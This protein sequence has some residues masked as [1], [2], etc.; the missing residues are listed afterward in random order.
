M[1]NSTLKQDSELLLETL[2]NL[3]QGRQSNC[4][5]FKTF[6]CKDG[7]V[8]YNVS[9]DFQHP[10]KD[11]VKS[12]NNDFFLVSKLP[13]ANNSVH[14]DSTVSECFDQEADLTLPILTRQ[15][16]FVG[17]P[18]S[19]TQYHLFQRNDLHGWEAETVEKHL[20]LSSVKKLDIKAAR[21]FLSLYIQCL[22]L[23][24]GLPEVWLLCNSTNPQEVTH[25]GMVPHTEEDPKLST[26]SL[27]QVNTVV[28]RNQNISAPEKDGFTL[29]EQKKMHVAFNKARHADTH[30]FARYNIFGALGSFEKDDSHPESSITMEF[31]WDGVREILQPP[32]PS[33]N[34]VLNIC[35][36]PEDVKNI[37]PAITSEL[38]AL[39][40]HFAVIHGNLCESAEEED[41]ETFDKQELEANVRAFL[42]DLK[43]NS[44]G[45]SEPE[46]ISQS[47]SSNV[48]A[49]F[50][51][52]E[53]L[54]R[55]DLDN[56]E[57]L[58]LFFKDFTSAEKIVFCLQII[59]SS[60]FQGEYQPV[61][62]ATNQTLIGKLMKGVVCCQTEREKAIIKMEMAQDFNT[63]AALECVLEIGLEKL[64]KDYTNYFFK[65]ELVTKDRLDYYLA[66]DVPMDEKVQRLLKLHCILSLVTLAISYAHIK[67]HDLRELVVAALKFYEAHSHTEHPIFSLS[68][69]AFSASSD[70]KNVC[71][72]QFQPQTWMVAITTANEYITVVKVEE[73]D[74]NGTIVESLLEQDKSCKG[75]SYLA[76][77]ATVSQIFI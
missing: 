60:L 75:G 46:S 38:N 23:Q 11:I 32:P 25:M 43:L 44:F 57:C 9:S 76:T 34:A 53:A 10:L 74:E 41:Q 77:T 64:R 22:C 28:V 37:L 48:T 19:Q 70:V 24:K 6:D 17:T 4:I 13:I 39:L 69:P 52:A 31:A 68:L 42:E 36:H 66:K 40:N 67:Y 51:I 29:K 50:G 21:Y 7:Y 12:V 49:P 15:H 14:D 8:I 18:I 33:S 45:S 63:S 55:Q 1:A 5:P 71:I 30:G 26:K 72:R 73:N 61:L 27:Q 56:T 35:A 16:V 3:R 58:W 59:F 54:R 65:Q 20:D 47:P 62:C 2:N